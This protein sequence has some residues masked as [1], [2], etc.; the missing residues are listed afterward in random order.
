VRGLLLNAAKTSLPSPA[1][2]TSQQRSIPSLDG[3]RA[4][5]VSLVILAHYAFGGSF[6]WNSYFFQ[7]GQLG[8]NIFFVI[9]GFLITF[10]LSKEQAATSTISLKNFYQ[11]RAW[12]IF[13]PFY[14]Y[15]AA[16][17]L[18]SWIGIFHLRVKEILIAG[19]YLWNYYIPPYTNILGHTW[20]LALE[21]QFY[22]LWPL[23]LKLAKP[24][25]AIKIAVLLI[26]I[27][28]LIRVAEYLLFAQLRESGK[29]ATNFHTRIDTLMFGCLI[30]LLWR[31]AHF[32]TFVHRFVRR[33]LF[34][35][36]VVFLLGLEPILNIYSRSTYHALW[37]TCDG[38]AISIALIYLVR[39]PMTVAGRF[40][41]LRP[42]RFVGELSYSLYLWQQ[43]FVDAWRRRFPLNLLAA[44]CCAA[45]SFYV[46]ERPSLKLRDRF[47]QRRFTKV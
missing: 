17:G 22:L 13:P 10:L 36:S 47:M 43:I 11:R 4:I 19:A 30:A 37:L 44:I 15:L 38:A 21:E 23:C 26:I 39:Y 31:H 5:S 18:F 9:S 35:C 25:R 16:A 24:T 46:I 12:R 3:L 29:I 20:T 33:P 1:Q 8:V 7:L 6:F 14:L 41:N 45:L 34:A 40:V 2:L 28:P 42:M 32:A 27:E